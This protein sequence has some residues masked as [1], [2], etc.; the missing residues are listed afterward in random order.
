MQHTRL[1]RR[2]RVAVGT[3]LSTIIATTLGISP[4]TAAPTDRLDVAFSGSLVGTTSYTA[5]WNEVYRGVLQR[6]DGAEEQL[7]GGGVRLAGGNQGLTF[8]PRDLTLG[9]TTVD[10]GFLA[11]VEFTPTQHRDLATILSAGGNL[12]VRTRGSSLEYGF[13]AR[14]PDGSWTDVKGG[15]G[16]SKLAVGQR[17]QL[18]VT[19][20]PTSAGTEMH[21]SV[22]GHAMQ[23]LTSPLHAGLSDGLGSRFGFGHEVHPDG[24]GRGIV[25]TLH[26]IRLAAADRYRADAYEFQRPG[27]AEADDVPCTPL[28]ASLQPGNQIEVSHGDCASNILTKAGL[29]RPTT[30][31]LSWQEAGLT[32]FVHY[33]VNTYYDQEWGHGTEDPARFRPS[34]LDPRKWA[35]ALREAGFRYV[36]LT[37]KH[38]DG[39]LLYPSRYTDHDISSTP[40]KAGKGDVL[41]ELTDAARQV[42]LK[43]GFYLSPA[44]SNA[45]LKGVFGNGSAKKT[46]T[47]PT[48]VPGDDRTGH[49]SRFYTYR[50]TDYG[51]YFLN[52]LYEVLTQYGRVDEVWFDGA[53]GNTAKQ[54]L[55]DYDAYYDLIHHLQPHAVIA[56]GGSD[57]RWIG[58]EGGVARQ[59]EWATMPVRRNPAVGKLDLVS[60]EGRDSIPFDEEHGSAQ[61]LRS[62]VQNGGAEHLHWWPVEADMK[63]TGGWFAH[64][65]DHP[66]SGQELFQHYLQTQGRNAVMLLNVPPTTDGVFSDASVASIRAFASERR[67]AFSLDHA[68]G[69]P[70]TVGQHTLATLTDENLRSAGPALSGQQTFT[71]DLGVP[72]RVDFV[73]LAEDTL[74]AGQ[75][76]AAFRV[77]AEVDGSWQPVATAGTIGV[78]RTLALPSPVRAQRFRVVVTQSRGA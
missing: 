12:F 69:R 43:V 40:W 50:A 3:A 11:E 9:S 17:H 45:E 53:M 67:K 59:N 63:L 13:S 44:D 66:K 26:R 36:I 68:L 37:V 14:R 46:R 60:A 77:E 56:V 10:H 21:V 72:R 8:T 52:Q 27:G 5:Q 33:G 71:V 29:V 73:S 74:H 7:A 76:V 22:D 2:W 6:V 39:F 42:G 78:R 55:F 15:L 20:V 19:V 54:E 35:V 31:Q 4:A 25:G 47:I 23:P 18:G 75:K 30:E 61:H 70:V 24:T 57:V 16:L 49:V 38:H 32:A 58:N 51:Q 28:P 1:P 48:L 64:P 34:R 62:A 65:S 41:K